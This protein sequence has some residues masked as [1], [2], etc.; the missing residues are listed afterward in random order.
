MNIYAEVSAISQEFKPTYLYI[1]RHKVSGLLYLGKTTGTE[2]YLLEQYNGSGSY[3]TNHLKMHGHE[4]ET[5]WY[6]LFTEKDELVKFA[7]QCSAQWDIVK[8]KD[9]SGKKLWANEKPE[10]G[11]DGGG[12]RGEK[13]GM[14]GKTHTDEVKQMQAQRAIDLFKGKTYEEIHGAEKA[15]DLKRDKSQKLK[16]YIK[17]NPGVRS[18]NKNPN[19]KIYKFTDPE[20]NVHVITGGLKSFCKDHGLSVDR[21]IDVVKNRKPS[22]KEWYVRYVIQ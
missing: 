21:I 11:L 10:N 13:N 15:E 22:Y 3:W 5:V 20:G 18:G 9:A 4:V 17:N 2:K 8:S 14:Y 7:L 19:A 6:C 16:S 1:K 12:Q